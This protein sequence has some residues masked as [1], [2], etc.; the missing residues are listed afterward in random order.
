[1]TGNLRG[2]QGVCTLPFCYI[3]SLTIYLR[4]RESP[5]KEQEIIRQLS[6]ENRRLNQQYELLKQTILEEFNDPSVVPEKTDLRM[7]II[8]IR[9]L[10]LRARQL[11]G[12]L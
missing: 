6:A 5:M 1:M 8:M 7:L 12:K 11:M 4:G 2:E 3:G 9:S 10:G